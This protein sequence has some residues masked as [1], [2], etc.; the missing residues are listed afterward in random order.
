[1][2]DDA[3]NRAPALIERLFALLLECGAVLR[4][5]EG[6]VAKRQDS[7]Y[8]PGQRSGVEV[9]HRVSPGQELVVGGYL[10][11]GRHFDALLVE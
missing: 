5:L 10:S 11:G 7:V 1:V 3:L 2:N 4:E 6:V 8:E 9:K